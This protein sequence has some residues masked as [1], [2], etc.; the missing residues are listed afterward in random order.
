MIKMPVSC[1]FKEN[2][3]SLID[4]EIDSLRKECECLKVDIRDEENKENSNES[5]MVKDKE[6]LII[7]ER[8]LETLSGY[9][10]IIGQETCVP[11]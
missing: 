8:Q 1:D 4:R 7:F 3:I 6:R 11:G 9:R 10:N 2:M 5:F